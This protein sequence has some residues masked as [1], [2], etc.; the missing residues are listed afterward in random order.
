MARTPKLRRLSEIRWYLYRST[1]KIQMLY[2]QL[3]SSGGPL[4]G[5][6]SVGIPG[7]DIKASL[8]TSVDDPPTDDEKLEL[9]EQQL[10]AKDMIGTTQE[11][12]AYF[13][14][15]LPM[16]WGLFNDYGYRPTN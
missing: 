12:K 2:E 16:R 1:G 5:N 3:V 4:K 8:G 11:P 6:L 7:T 10:R 15:E 13:A 14:G 9:I